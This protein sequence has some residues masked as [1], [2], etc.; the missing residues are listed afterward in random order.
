MVK[1]IEDYQPQDW[2]D[3]ISAIFQDFVRYELDVKENIGY[4]DY[5]RS[6]HLV[7]IQA[8]AKRSG[9]LTM[10]DSLP[11]KMDTQLGKTFAN[12][13]QLSGG[14]WQKNCYCASL[15][16]KSKFIYS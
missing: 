15:Y 13:I 12:G 10:I 5:K 2:Q 11:D 7:A 14:Q 4:G 3:R 9:A 16:E 8:A 6:N 1:R